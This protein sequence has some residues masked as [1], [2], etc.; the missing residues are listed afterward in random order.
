MTDVD[1]ENTTPFNW[2]SSK[3]SL[4]CDVVMKGGI[5]SGVVYPRAVTELAKTYRLRSVGGS[6]AGAIGAALAAAAEFGRHSETGGF[7]R[8][9]QIPDELGDGRLAGLFQPQRATRA[10]L[11]VLLA[12]TG[13]GPA[14]RNGRSHRV[15]DTVLALI[16]SFPLATILGLLPGAAAIVLGAYSGW[17]AGV[18]LLVCGIILLIVGWAV[19]VGI[20]LYR[21][22]A[23]AL[24]GNGFG[25]CTGLSESTA[26]ALTDWL[27][28][29]IDELAGLGAEH[30]PLTFGDLWGSDV[31]STEVANRTIDLRMMSTCLSQSRPYELPWQACNFFYEPAVWRQLFPAAVMEALEAAPPATASTPS[32]TAR[33]REEDKYA[34][35]HGP[36]LRRL[37]DAAHLPV[38]VATRMSLSFPVL[39]SAVPLWRIDHLHRA[40]PDHPNHG[41]HFQSL[42]FSDGGLTSNFPIHL[43]DAALPTRPTFA[44]NLGRF[45]TDWPESADERENVDLA[46][47]NSVLPAPYTAI[48]ASGISAIIGFGAATINTAREWSDNAR[49]DQPGY[50]DRI[51][52]VLQTRAQ[53]GLNLHMDSATIERLARRGAVAADAIVGQFNEPRYRLGS[54][55]PQTGW[56]NHRWVRYRALLSTLPPFLASYKRGREVLGIDP[57]DPPSYELNASSRELA[58]KLDGN[59]R[60]AAGVNNGHRGGL[61]DLVN[62]PRPLSALGRTPKL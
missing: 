49:L 29:R 4:E 6:S 34:E 22:L 60:R 36:R 45:R 51:V 24:P 52:R 15:L 8:L 26:P 58:A 61:D 38:I 59:L 35:T 44:I 30:G 13:N 27:T 25:V 46:R 37:P 31:E 10:L 33:W 21:K 17:P 1:A 14:S 48:P 62:E 57:E 11:P 39:I 23:H 42:W 54:D 5:T 3:P 2:R 56:D 47:N 40:D 32:K 50:R 20:R 12:A 19:A 55:T 7:E 16:R 18:A 43:F 53:G 41:P 28:S 9:E